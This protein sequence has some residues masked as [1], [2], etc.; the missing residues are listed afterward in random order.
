M[1]TRRNRVAVPI[2][3]REESIFVPMCAVPA[4]MA[5]LSSGAEG[6]TVA[7]SKASGAR[8]DCDQATQKVSTVG[9]HFFP[10]LW[11]AYTEGSLDRD[12]AGPAGVFICGFGLYQLPAKCCRFL[13]LWLM[14]RTSFGRRGDG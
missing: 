1:Q 4:R 11:K 5:A 14:S 10:W 12:D 6:F 3:T 2:S 8:A 7:T 13:I 9:K